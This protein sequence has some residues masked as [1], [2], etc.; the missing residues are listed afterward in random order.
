[1]FSLF[2]EIEAEDEDEEKILEAMSKLKGVKAIIS[3]R[4]EKG[5]TLYFDAIKTI[6]K[7]GNYEELMTVEDAGENIQFMIRDEAGKISEL[8]MVIGGKEN[9][10][11]MTLYGEIDLNSIAKLSRVLKIKGM[12]AFQALDPDQK[13]K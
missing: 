4:S 10:M 12:D 6:E 7:D 9:F 5:K 3:N 11:V 8:L 13:K 2:T 1:M